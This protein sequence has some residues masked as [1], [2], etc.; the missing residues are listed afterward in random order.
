MNMFAKDRL[1]ESEYVAWT[2]FF[3]AIIT[4]DDEFDSTSS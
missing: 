2:C 4:Q 3:E 1:R